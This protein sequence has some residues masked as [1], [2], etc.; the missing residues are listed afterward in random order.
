M[1]KW[2]LLYKVRTSQSKLKIEEVL[3]ILLENRG[4]KTKKEKSEF[5]NLSLSKISIKSV[6]ID[7][8][9]L[10][11]TIRRIK[12]AINSKEKAIVFGDYDVDGICGSAILW[13]TLTNLGA[14]TLPYI[15]SRF[16]EGYGL[17]IKGI[18][19]VIKEH[20][21]LSLI[22]TVDNGIVAN[23]AV[24]YANKKGI[25]VI[26]TDHHLKPVN[27]KLPKAY[28]II[29]TTKL[30]GAGVAYLLSKELKKE[31]LGDDAHLELVTLATIADLVPL[32]GVNRALVYY[33]LQS[34]RK[35]KRRG[36]LAL[37]E[38]AAINK[39]TI[40]VYEVG[41]IIAPRLNAMGRLTS[42]MDSLRLI[43]TSNQDRANALAEVLAKTNLKR[44]EL[45]ID[46]LNHAIEGAKKN[47]LKNL[48]FIADKSYQEGIIGLV[49]GRLVEE[50]YLPSIVISKGEKYSK[51]SARSVLGFNIV[52]FLR[53]SS[54]LLVDVGGHPMAAG[55]TVETK[56]LD[57]LEKTLYEK[58]SK[59]L[60][61]KHLERKLNIDMALSE[62]LITPSFYLAIQKL[63]PFGMANP[64][65]LFLTNN[66]RVVD[67]KIVGKDSKH[68]K[69]R[70]T[71]LNGIYFDA[72]AFG[73]GHSNSIAIGDN[74]S[75]V[76]T[77]ALN[78]WNGNKKLQLKVKDI[79]RN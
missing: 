61:K 5:L 13:E 75:I 77:L 15:P 67:I 65:P 35:T 43:C 79:N 47:L 73:M 37:Y 29:H 55:F 1:K 62:N 40:G 76:Y 68:L 17:S 45:T 31:K 69:M 19:N 70:L 16:E 64:E 71:T 39:E 12:K 54:D 74:V 32:T 44:Q 50:Y 11:K 9:E 20:P 10:S 34:L 60:N 28:S 52:E 49:A 25:D 18:D 57:L 42:A 36:L 23:D 7:S 8:K 27:T 22:I 53:E 56:N 14:D 58:V 51:A 72:I 6:G 63:A 21:S 4:V 26:I 66:L 38:K 59:L 2:N 41:H 30:C 78:E 24:D 48:I 33:G 3:D 46:T